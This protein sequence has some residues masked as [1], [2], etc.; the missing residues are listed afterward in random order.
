MALGGEGGRDKLRKAAV[1]GKCLVTRGC[2]NGETRRERSRHCGDRA[3]G[4]R[5]GTETTQDPQEEEITMVAP[6]VASERGRAQTG[7]VEAALGVVGPP[8]EA[9]GR[10][11]EHAGK[12]DRRG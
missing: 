2:P 12:R 4:R 10:V 11:A 5:G 7:A 9:A 3:A 8:A 1:R 6:V